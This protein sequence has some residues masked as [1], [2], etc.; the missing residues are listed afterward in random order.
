MIHRTMTGL[1]LGLLLLAPVSAMET[2]V[3]FDGTTINDWSTARDQARLDQEFSVSELTGDESP[4]SLLWRFVSKGVAF[5]RPVPHASHCPRLRPVP[6]TR[7]KRRRA[8][9]VGLQGEG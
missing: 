4:P 7:E 2:E 1:T 9:P 5:Q 3:L 8:V 6:R